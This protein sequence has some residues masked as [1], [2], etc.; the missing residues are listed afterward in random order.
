MMGETANIQ[1]I[2]NLPYAQLIILRHKTPYYHKNET[3]IPSKIEIINDKCILKYIKLNF[4]ISQAHRP[5]CICIFII[6]I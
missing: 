3:E 5:N 4:D 2:G 1:A 6:D